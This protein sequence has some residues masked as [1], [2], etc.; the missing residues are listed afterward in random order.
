[1]GGY[2]SHFS[3]TGCCGI[4]NIELAMLLPGDEAEKLALA[5]HDATGLRA[6]LRPVYCRTCGH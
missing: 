1:M 3:E 2:L 6:A 4:D 5:F